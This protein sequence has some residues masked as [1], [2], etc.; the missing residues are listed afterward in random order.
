MTAWVHYELLFSSENAIV[1]FYYQECEY[2]RGVLHSALMKRSCIIIQTGS[3]KHR[4]AKY[5]EKIQGS[6]KM[7]KSH[8][9]FRF[10]VYLSPLYGPHLK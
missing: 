7:S 9:D 3:A 2:I 4:P 10:V 8:L 5:E 6:F 1:G